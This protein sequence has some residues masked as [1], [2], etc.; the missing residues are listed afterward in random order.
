MIH[1]IRDGEAIELARPRIAT[2]KQ[3]G[4]RIQS[5]TVA[6]MHGIRQHGDRDRCDLAERPR[7]AVDARQRAAG[8]IAS[9][10]EES[11]VATVAVQGHRHLVSCQFRNEICWHHRWISK[12]LAVVPDET[13]NDP[14]RIGFDDQLLVVGFIAFGDHPRVPRLIKVGLRKADREGFHRRGAQ[15]RHHCNNCRGVHPTRQERTERDV[16]NQPQL[17]RLGET[18]HELTGELLGRSTISWRVGPR[19]LPIPLRIANQE[20]AVPTL[21]NDQAV[22]CRQLVNIGK[23]GTWSRDIL[24]TEIVVDGGGIRHDGRHPATR[25]WP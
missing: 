6:T 21:T 12:R 13:R 9:I 22:S 10:P 3:F 17:Y 4:Q 5:S 18:F 8:R 23:G 1:E 20:D 25:V 14:S 11:L 24:Q 19:Q 16:G 7:Q 15:T 2:A